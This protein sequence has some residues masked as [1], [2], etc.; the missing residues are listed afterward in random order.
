MTRSIKGSPNKILRAVFFILAAIWMMSSCVSQ[1]KMLLLQ[2]DNVID[3]TYAKTFE[4][5]QFEDSIYHILPNDYLYISITSI[6]KQ[7][8]QFLEPVAGVNFINSENQALVGYHVTDE[9]NIFYPYIGNIKL[10]GLTIAEARDTMKSQ[11]KDLV[12]L[13]RVD[14]ILINN[15]VHMLGE[16]TKQ[17]TL[18]MSRSKLSIYEA[19]ALAG[20]LTENANL[21]QIK[22]LRTEMG[23]KKVYLIDLTSVNLIGKNMFYVF[24][25]D[26]IYAEPLKAKS[27]VVTP[28]FYISAVSTLIT[29]VLFIKTMFF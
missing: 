4:G 24:P 27:A 12:G 26:V 21:Q 20:G 28:A 14:I 17:G 7:I 23:I 13:C 8:T 19:V 6:D 15:Y 1:K 25:N 2:S 11:I 10:G 29:L 5:R 3:S 18:N 9:G 16:F 22:I